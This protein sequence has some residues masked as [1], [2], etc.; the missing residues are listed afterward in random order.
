ML[1]LQVVGKLREELLQNHTYMQALRR[2]AN[3]LREEAWP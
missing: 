3:Q 2:E 1:T